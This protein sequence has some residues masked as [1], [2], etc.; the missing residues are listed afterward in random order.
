M[1][2]SLPCRGCCRIDIKKLGRFN[3]IGHRI[4]GDQTGRAN[5]RSRGCAPGWEFVHV[6]IDD[7]SR[8]AFTKIMPDEKKESAIAF[9]EAAL[10]YYA[11]L[12]V[13][14][15]RGMTDNG[16]SYAISGGL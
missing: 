6:C 10:A 2:E 1:G 3:K 13:A 7:A 5:D 14:V 16:P 8:V 9:L 4:T 15:Q 11:S 12:G